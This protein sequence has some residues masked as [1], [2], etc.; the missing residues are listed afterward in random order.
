MED[1]DS[2]PGPGRS[3]GE[4]NGSPLQYSCLEN[5]RDRGTWWATVLRSQRVRHDRVTNTHA[6]CPIKNKPKVSGRRICYYGGRVRSADVGLWLFSYPVW[7]G[8]ICS[9]Q[10]KDGVFK[11]LSQ[12][13]C[14]VCLLGRQDSYCPARNLLNNRNLRDNLVC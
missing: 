14:V 9:I 12:R 2:I 1:L 7:A 13:C 10:V 5:S 4:R 11:R 3:P 6:L 8:R